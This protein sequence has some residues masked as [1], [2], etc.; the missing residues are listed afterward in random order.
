MLVQSNK[1]D[2]IPDF[3]MRCV[4][5]RLYQASAHQ[6]CIVQVRNQH[7]ILPLFGLCVCMYVCVYV[8]MCAKYVCMYVRMYVC[9]KYACMYVC[10]YVRTYVWSEINT[11]SSPSSGYVYLCMY[12]YMYVCALSMYVCMCVCMYVR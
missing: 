8:C 10:M 2:C 6:R 5:P 1:S 11:I 12:V 9:A 7:Y 4:Y 3:Y